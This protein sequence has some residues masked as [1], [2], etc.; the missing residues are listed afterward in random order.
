MINGKQRKQ[1]Q[2]YNEWDRSVEKNWLLVTPT[3]LPKLSVKKGNRKHIRWKAPP[4]GW[5]KLN[6]YGACH[7]NPGVSGFGVVIHNSEDSTILIEGSVV[8]RKLLN[9]DVYC[10]LSGHSLYAY[11]FKLSFLSR[12]YGNM[13]FFGSILCVNYEDLRGQLQKKKFTVDAAYD[14]MEGLIG[15][16]LNHQR[17][18]C[19]SKV[20]EATL[21]PVVDV[22][23]SSEIMVGIL[24]G[25]FKPLLVDAVANCILSLPSNRRL[26]ILKVYFQME[27]YLPSDSSEEG[28]L[29]GDGE[30]SDNDRNNR[31][32]EK[33]LAKMEER[34]KMRIFSENAWEVFRC[35]VLNGNLEPFR[36]VT[37]SEE[38][39]LSDQSTSN[40]IHVG[41]CTSVILQALRGN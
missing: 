26:S 19:D 14:A 25:F 35:T 24:D 20:L 12:N 32:M 34:E 38:W 23:K 36:R 13:A 21:I 40:V 18:W 22:L 9:W 6:F 41:E 11:I 10:Y 33:Y 7:G 30:E 16:A 31:A 4:V 28:S 15:V 37:R 27:N 17:H 8:W 3:Q 1:S 39:W 5:L 29:E 2:H